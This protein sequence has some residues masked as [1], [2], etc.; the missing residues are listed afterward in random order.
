MGKPPMHVQAPRFDWSFNFGHILTSIATAA[1]VAG[2]I[3]W[4]SEKI[5]GFEYRLRASEI[6]AQTYIPLI[7]G[8]LRSDTKQDERITNLV[9]AL[10]DLRTAIANDNRATRAE[11]AEMTK[12]VGNLREGMAG[13]NAKLENVQ[14]LLRPAA[15]TR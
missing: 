6:R 15:A 5:A 7:D 2:G 8:M 13:A 3:W 1:S 11:F 10:S 12:S 4:A 14:N 9:S